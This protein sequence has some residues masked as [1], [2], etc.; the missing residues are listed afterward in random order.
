MTDTIRMSYVEGLVEVQVG[1][2]ALKV[3]RRANEA[4]RHMCPTELVSVA[5]GG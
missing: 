1:G 5:L 2:R 3:D 4:R